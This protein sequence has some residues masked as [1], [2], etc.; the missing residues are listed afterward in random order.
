MALYLPNE[1][2]FVTVLSNCDG[3]ASDYIALKLAA[4]AIGKPFAYTEIAMVNSELERYA[5]VYENESGDQLLISMERAKLYVQRGRG[6]K[7]NA[8][9]YQKDHFFFNDG[10]TTMKFFVAT[11]G[12]AEKLTVLTRN[13][14]EIWKKSDKPILSQ[15]EVIVDEKILE[16]YVGQ[17]E[18]TPRFIFTITKEGNRLYLQATGQEK[19]EVFA[20]TMNK[21]FLKV[22][23]ARLEF[24]IESGRVTKA[25]LKQ[26][27]RT[28]DA[29]KIK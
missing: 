1:D 24:V 25:I 22:N 10:M 11:T 7:V 15:T 16:M 14:I 4:A 26:G 6:P 2:V 19:L 12:K 27:G 3:N 28:T 20:E 9:P 13:G 23:D 18:V 21:F 17:Y 8:K 29:I 5:G